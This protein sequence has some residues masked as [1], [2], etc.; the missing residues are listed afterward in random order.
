MQCRT[1]LNLTVKV[2][3]ATECFIRAKCSDDSPWFIIN[4]TSGKRTQPPSWLVC[5]RVAR[6]SPQIRGGGRRGIL[7]VV[8]MR[9]PGSQVRQCVAD[10]LNAAG[11]QVGPGRQ[12]RPGRQARP[13]VARAASTKRACV[14][15]VGMPACRAGWC[16]AACC[17]WHTATGIEGPWVAGGAGGTHDLR[18]RA[19]CQRITDVAIGT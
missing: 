8:P 16:R 3:G 15:I 5:W 17:S 2:Y 7:D 1:H 12:E 9:M 10:V 18:L 14:C 19:C 13:Q 4:H 6:H 11:R